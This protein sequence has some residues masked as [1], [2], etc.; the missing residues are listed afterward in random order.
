[1]P[2]TPM[3]P[4]CPRGGHCAAFCV[5]PISPCTLAAGAHPLSR[6]K[7]WK[8]D[9]PLAP[10]ARHVA[11]RR[12][13]AHARLGRGRLAV[14][15]P[16]HGGLHEMAGAPADVAVR[17]TRPD[18]HGPDLTRIACGGAAQ[19]L[20]GGTALPPRLEARPGDRAH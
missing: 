18:L 6:P 8:A 16:L 4:N 15:G 13:R 12:G 10:T 19:R 20:E 7:R 17:A 5:A 11:R 2:R 1:M 9:A 14:A 3:S